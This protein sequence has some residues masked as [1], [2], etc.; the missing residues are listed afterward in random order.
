MITNALPDIDID[1]YKNLNQ[2]HNAAHESLSK[3]SPKPTPH[4]PTIRSCRVI[5]VPVWILSHP[6]KQ[7]QKNDPKAIFQA[8][9]A[10][11][12]NN[13][14]VESAAMNPSCC[15]PH[16]R[17]RCLAWVAMMWMHHRHSLTTMLMHHWDSFVLVPHGS[18]QTSN[19]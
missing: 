1:P 7:S 5:L 8:L 16:S 15:F 6:R 18:I 4:D 17:R 3:F 11:E 19:S 13:V 10:W 2:N 9:F 12:T 14:P